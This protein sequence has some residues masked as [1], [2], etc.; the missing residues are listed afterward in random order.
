MLDNEIVDT[1]EQRKKDVELINK[2][3]AAH[4]HFCNDHSAMLLAKLSLFIDP[5]DDKALRILANVEFRMGRYMA[6][7]DCIL[8]IETHSK[9]SLDNDMR[10]KKAL[11]LGK[12]GQV[13]AGRS[14]LL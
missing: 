10:I 2:M 8:D 7:L 14:V 4:F 9:E 12:L 13:D 11:C 5:S 6:A 3:A 1:P